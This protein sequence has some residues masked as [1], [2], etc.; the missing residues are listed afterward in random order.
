MKIDETAGDLIIKTAEKLG[1][2]RA[3]VVENSDGMYG[4][5]IWS[6]P[7]PDEKR[8]AVLNYQKIL[9]DIS[10]GVP[11]SNETAGLSKNE[12]EKIARQGVAGFILMP[13]TK[14]SEINAVIVFEESETG[15]SRSA[16]DLDEI[17]QLSI[18]I[19]ETISAETKK[20]SG[21]SEEHDIYEKYL[22]ELINDVVLRVKQNGTIVDC[23]GYTATDS[24]FSTDEIVGL[25]IVHFA[26]KDDDVRT[27]PWESGKDVIEYVLSSPWVELTILYRT[28]E[29]HWVQARAFPITSLTD[30]PEYLCC[31]TDIHIQKMLE[32]R[33]SDLKEFHDKI[34]NNIVDVVW[35]I[36]LETLKYT[37]M[38]PSDKKARGYETEEAMSK[39][40][41][42]IMP[43]EYHELLMTALAEEWE[44]EKKGI[45]PPDRFQKVPM[46]E[47]CK[48]GSTFHSEMCISGIRDK[49]TGKPLELIGI[50]RNVEDQWKKEK[51]LDDQRESFRALADS[52]QDGLILWEYDRE[53]NKA[54]TSFVSQ[55]VP[56][57]G[58]YSHEQALRLLN[59]RKDVETVLGGKL[60]AEMEDILSD[61]KPM[62]PGIRQEY[63][64]WRKDRSIARVEASIHPFSY[65]VNE[66]GEKRKLLTIIRDISETRDMQI[67][68]EK[69]AVDAASQAFTGFLRMDGAIIEANQSL[70]RLVKKEIVYGIDFSELLE[71]HSSEVFGK[72]MGYVLA[73]KVIS[74]PFE[75][76]L[77]RG[78]GE[79]TFLRIKVC[80]APGY[81]NGVLVGAVLAARKIDFNRLSD[82]FINSVSM[83]SRELEYATDMH[84]NFIY[85]S[86]SVE[87]LLGYNVKTV[88][89][90]ELG[91]LMP[92]KR[93][94]ELV[95]TFEKGIMASRNKADFCES[96]K[97]SYNRVDGKAISGTSTVRLVYD[98]G[99]PAGFTV[100]TRFDD[101][102]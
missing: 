90:M 2:C 48:D 31:L 7:N 5:V 61:R 32:R 70:S 20:A 22:S 27:Q 49:T 51:E 78:K 46:I 100:L 75:L 66:V 13:V 17:L 88:S 52:M 87:N 42:E 97:V 94:H 39:D 43:P 58:G 50:S 76:V 6:W 68:F 28:G 37:Y 44:K 82:S 92:E 38:S 80:L 96:I 23:K 33:Y 53:G 91:T 67:M 18:Q 60:L 56:R 34:M 99:E 55:G 3:Q 74:E 81:R 57:I 64:I 36:D 16:E 25:N 19:S 30:E 15:K 63:D 72:E 4:H 35:I 102:K 26:R 59:S 21:F 62:Q 14:D 79:K 85:M 98:K 12:I 10:S 95:K 40:L 9:N 86:P 29:L 47:I 8:S 24:G 71:S 45:A 11:I 41:S 84:L 77:R 89:G 1:F 83:D 93:L 69:L 65:Y 101:S 73:R 54:V